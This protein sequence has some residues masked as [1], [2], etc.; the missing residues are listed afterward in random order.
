M[1]LWLEIRYSWRL[2][3]KTPGYSLLG[4]VVVGLS[5]GLAIWSHE[6]AY[7]MAFQPLPFAG[8]ERWMSLEMPS[9]PSGVLRPYVDAYTYQEILRRSPALTHLGALSERSSVLSEG[10]TSASL[11]TVAISPSLLAALHVAPELG[12]LFEP[13]DATPGSAP[14][15][16]LSFDAWQSYF[17]ADA[18]VIGRSARID[19]RPVKV[20]GVMPRDLLAFQ[21]FEL[22]VPLQLPALAKPADSSVVLSPIIALQDGQDAAAVARELQLPV[23]EVNRQ[24][25]ALF[26]A[27]RRVALIPAH[28]MYTHIMLEIVSTVAFIAFAVLLLGCVNISMVFLARLIE[29]RRELAIR[30]ALGSSRWHLLRQSLLESAVI[31]ALGLAG[32]LVLAYLGIRWMQMLNLAGAQFEAAGR[33]PGDYKLRPADVGVAVLAAVAVW[34]LSTLAPAWR[35]TKQ[36]AAVVLAGGSKGA[37]GSTGSRGASVLVGVQVLVASVVLVVC[38]NIVAAVRDLAAA[39][40]G[41]AA[42]T[43][44]VISMY[45]TAFE[46]RHRMPEERLRYW[47]ELTRAIE[48][49]ISGAEVALMTSPP[50]RPASTP[51]AIDGQEGS[52]NRGA[53]TMPLVAVSET[54]FHVLGLGLLGGRLF[55]AN[56]DG[57]TLNVAIVDDEAAQHYWPNQAV[58]GKRLQLSPADHG[59]WLTIVGVVSSVP[60]RPFGRDVGTVYRPLRQATPAAF[61]LAVKMPDAASDRRGALRA[62][63]YAVDRDL[64]LN[65]LQLLED[66]L[67][68]LRMSYTTMAPVFTL[69]SAITVLLAASG[70]FGLISRS[71]A[72]RTQEVGIRRALGGTQWQVTAVFLREGMAYLALAVIGV[73]LGIGLSDLIA[74]SIPNI[75]A[76]A[77]ATTTGVLALMTLVIFVASYLPTRQAIA[78]EPGDALRYE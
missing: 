27:E 21:D 10:Q 3:F 56:D 49:R 35:V 69:I 54:Y 38:M 32:G 22:W 1:N 76:H 12:R 75:L 52:T 42:A 39:P 78:L 17:A 65:N 2:L 59:P 47:S 68:N 4:I 15:A 50:S 36:D 14:L 16:I 20:V 60:G 34:L 26:K 41:L 25:P 62:A 64:P 9:T 29:R 28:R 74:R 24:Y 46:A 23:D 7:A 31:V 71:V 77:V 11:R 45:P 66:Y 63:A 73:G 67:R 70:L 57:A 53:Y 5:L 40:T 6:L 13:A 72:R 30:T 58:V 33:S 61:H 55:D 48:S 44:V 18:G 51:V 37:S 43:Q 19:G 8:S